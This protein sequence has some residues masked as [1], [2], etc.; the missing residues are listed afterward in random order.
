MKEKVSVIVPVYNN[1]DTIKETLNSLIKQKY[2]NVE[3]IVVDDCSTDDTY[4]FVKHHYGDVAKVIR[5][6]SN[7][8]P[9]GARNL[10]IRESNGNYI[11]FLDSDDIIMPD[12]IEVL[13]SSALKCGSD[14]LLCDY[15]KFTTYEEIMDEIDEGEVFDPVSISKFDFLRIHGYA[16]WGV[17]IKK[18]LIDDS[19]FPENVIAEDIYSTPLLLSEASSVFYLKK[20]LFKYKVEQRNS[21][22]SNIDKHNRAIIYSL[23][24][25]NNEK[26]IDNEILHY[27]N[28]LLIRYLYIKGETVGN[29]SISDEIASLGYKHRGENYIL[30]IELFLTSLYIKT[31]VKYFLKL[32]LVIRKSVEFIFNK[33]KN[34]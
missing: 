28:L 20:E 25:L 32:M 27:V 7:R 6:D 23:N 11:L 2:Q 14:L 4:D 29:I 18:G 15:G 8:G 16:P 17:L 24:K 1:T 10:G 19:L 33:R 9:G 22:T 5:S 30:S 12:C 31:K 26:K 34:N 13:V 21:I 3:I